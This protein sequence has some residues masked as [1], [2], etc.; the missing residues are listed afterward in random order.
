MVDLERHDAQLEGL[1]VEAVLR[2]GEFLASNAARLWV[3]A[4]RGRLQAVLFPEGLRFS[5]GRFGTTVTTLLFNE[6]GPEEPA[7]SSLATLEGV[8][9]L[10]DSVDSPAMLPPLQRV[11]SRDPSG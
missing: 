6:V 4:D 8:W 5:N 3:E 11:V 7:G 2:Y 9:S 1:D 10:P